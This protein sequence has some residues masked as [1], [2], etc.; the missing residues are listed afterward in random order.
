M[1]SYFRKKISRVIDA[2]HQKLRIYP[3]HVL[4]MALFISY[5]VLIQAAADIAIKALGA[6]AW[7]P[8][9]PVRTAFIFL[10]AVSAL[11]GYQALQGFR[12]REVDVTRNSVAIGVLVETGLIADDIVHIY[13][14]VDSHPLV[15]HIRLPFIILTAI[16]LILLI[17]IANKLKLFRNDQ[18]R[19]TLT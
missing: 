10:T 11:M 4:W 14:V 5:S 8:N 13:Q 17:Y 7:F 19:F 18:N 2:N 3:R 1:I 15:I 12:R 6:T 9:L 16:N